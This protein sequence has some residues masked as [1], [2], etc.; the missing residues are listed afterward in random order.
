MKFNA[1]ALTALVFFLFITHL[2]YSDGNYINCH[3]EDMND[4]T[5]TFKLYNSA[6]DMFTGNNPTDSV[7]IYLNKETGDYVN[8]PSNPNQSATRFRRWMSSCA[9]NESLFTISEFNRVMSR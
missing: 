9:A 4:S 7:I 8:A 2:V 5:H 6:V 3:P 1:I